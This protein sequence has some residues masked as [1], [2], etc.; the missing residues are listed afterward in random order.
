[1]GQCDYLE[2]RDMNLEAVVAKG[3]WI[4]G[5]N[6]KSFKQIKKLFYQDIAHDILGK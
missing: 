6:L 2:A 3:M 4:K 5:Q 1:M